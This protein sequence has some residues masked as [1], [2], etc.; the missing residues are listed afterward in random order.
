[1]SD[2]AF[3]YDI[4]INKCKDIFEKKL[5]DYGSSW[6]ILRFSSLID[7]IFIK[8]KRIRNIEE[9][10]L[11]KIQDDITSEYYGI[12]NYSI[13]CLI[14]LELG[15]FEVE[16][17]DINDD[18]YDLES[19]KI[20][21]LYNHFADYAKKL[22][23]DKNHDYGEAWVD[24]KITSLTDLILQKILR[25]KKID[26]NNHKT[27]VSEGVDSNLFDMINYCVFASIKLKQ[28]V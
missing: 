8:G 22:M 11:Q 18:S 4:I 15:V 28:N 25:I 2:T 3:E 21:S 13:I 1:M 9:T 19:D 5:K 12:I 16:K 7:Q 6:R 10:G 17:K 24:M 27:L 23:L 20:I 26:S 14:Q